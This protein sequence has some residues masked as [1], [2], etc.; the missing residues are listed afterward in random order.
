V[1]ASEAHQAIRLLKDAPDLFD[2]KIDYSAYDCSPSRY[3]PEGSH[4]KVIDFVKIVTSKPGVGRFTSPDTM[5][6]MIRGGALDL[7]GDARP[8]IAD[9]FLPSKIKAG[10]QED[11]RECIGCNLCISS[12]HDCVPVRCTQNPMAGEEWRR[13]WHPEIVHRDGAGQVLVVGRTGADEF[14]GRH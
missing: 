4:A 12:W 9:P 13:G 10:Q 1:A 3:T 7:I 6:D 11:I 8:S 2:V 5:L 14:H